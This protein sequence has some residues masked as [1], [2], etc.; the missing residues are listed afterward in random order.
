MNYPVIVLNTLKL[1][2][3]FLLIVSLAG[4]QQQVVKT[5]SLPA[6]DPGLHQSP[7]NIFTRNTRK[8]LEDQHFVIHFQDKVN[9]VENLGYTIQLDFAQG[10]TITANGMT[11]AFKQM[12]FHT[13]SE[14]L[15]DGMTYPMELHI[16]SAEENSATPHYLVIAVLFKMG[17]ENRFIN[18]F[19]N[20]VPER[21]HSQANVAT[22]VIKLSDLLSLTPTGDLG[23][24][25]HY[26][27]S[28]TT[29][30]YSENVNW[31]VLKTI[32]EA[33]PEQIKA[34]NNIEG[35]N[36]RHFE[37]DNDRIIEDN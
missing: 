37:P 4:C 9:T 5:Y 16:V 35:N 3:P 15:I 17:A 26:Q 18:D 28:L 19:L 22:G 21:G 12:H 1:F 20:T 32:F 29:P 36:A 27:G 7:I 23:H 14:H 34:I 30:P 13:P 25:Y 24:H 31:I 8:E 2:T 10:S 6:L 11:Y 33:S